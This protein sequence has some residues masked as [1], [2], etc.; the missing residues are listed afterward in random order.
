[1]KN[2]ACLAAFV[3]VGLGLARSQN[4]KA[5]HKPAEY[6]RRINQTALWQ[7]GMQYVPALHQACDKMHYPQFGECYF[8]VMQRAGASR[9]A[10]A[11]SRR[12][13]NQC[14]GMLA[15]MRGFR[16]TGRVDVAYAVCPFRA[17][18]N[19][20]CLLVNGSPEIIDVDNLR[21][22]PQAQLK[23]N[24]VYQ[25]LAGKYPAI[26]LWPGDR[27]GTQYPIARKLPDGGQ[28]FIVAYYLQNGCHACAHLGRA[29]FAFDFNR[30]GKFLGAQLLSVTSVA[31]QRAGPR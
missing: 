30:E 17:N 1:M 23:Q 26:D 29:R 4:Q 27:T 12:L 18:E 25:K 3:C 24:A 19:Q 11:F 10:V 31:P 20:V 8:E 9:E 21:L 13:A 5:A 15:F 28:R 7:P 2:F 14:N 6:T 22:L 16:N